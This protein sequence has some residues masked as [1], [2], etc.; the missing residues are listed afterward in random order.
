MER[1][2]THNLAVGSVCKLRAET[3]PTQP[4]RQPVYKAYKAWLLTLLV[5]DALRGLTLPRPPLPQVYGSPEAPTLLVDGKDSTTFKTCNFHSITAWKLQSLVDTRLSGL[6]GQIDHIGLKTSLK[7]IH[8]STADSIIVVH[9]NYAACTDAETYSY[10]VEI[11]P[12]VYKIRDCF[13]K[14]TLS[15]PSRPVK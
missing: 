7:R 11:S 2:R 9:C 5:T 8:S 6:T 13:T 14:M 1:T 10:V 15:C 12:L 3:L 4:P